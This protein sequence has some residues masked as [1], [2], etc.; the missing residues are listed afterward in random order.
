MSWLAEDMGIKEELWRIF[1]TIKHTVFAIIKENMYLGV[2]TEFI[3]LRMN[4]KVNY[5][6]WTFSNNDVSIRLH[7]WSQIASLR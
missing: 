1:K 3:T 2:S 5:E 7:Q 6:P 4:S